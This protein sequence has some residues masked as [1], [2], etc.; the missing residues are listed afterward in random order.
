MPD[1][2]PNDLRR[3]LVGDRTDAELDAQKAAHY[4]QEIHKQLDR[5]PALHSAVAGLRTPL[6]ICV[7]LLCVIALRGWHV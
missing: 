1:V 7:A 4:A 3:M 2:N 5:L 6:W